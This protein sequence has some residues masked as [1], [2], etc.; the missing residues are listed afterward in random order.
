MAAD[1]NLRHSDDASYL[2]SVFFRHAG[3]ALV[4]VRPRSQH[5]VADRD[6]GRRGEPVGLA[7]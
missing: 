2:H 6:S 7:H 4:W 3:L 5:E 1:A